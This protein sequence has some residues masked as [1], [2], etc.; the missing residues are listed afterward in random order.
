M[1]RLCTAGAGGSRAAGRTVVAAD[2]ADAASFVVRKESSPKVSIGRGDQGPLDLPAPAI[3]RRFGILFSPPDQIPGRTKPI[4]FESVAAQLPPKD[5]ETEG[6]RPHP[7][8]V[9]VVVV[10]AE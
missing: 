6:G 2:A 1:L 3:P 5:S 7:N 10:V 4:E 9:V 8:N